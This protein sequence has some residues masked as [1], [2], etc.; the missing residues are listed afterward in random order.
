MVAYWVDPHD[1][2]SMFAAGLSMAMAAN[3]LTPDETAR[4][5]PPEMPLLSEQISVFGDW[6]MDFEVSFRALHGTGNDA[7]LQA[8]E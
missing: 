8:A 1:P 2:V 3:G 5:W 4:M 7:A 6:L